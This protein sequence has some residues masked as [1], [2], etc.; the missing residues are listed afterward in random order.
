VS[1]DQINKKNDE[2]FTHFFQLHK[3]TQEQL[4]SLRQLCVHQQQ[5]IE[6]LEEKVAKLQM[7]QSEPDLRHLL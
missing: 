1:Q 3:L 7:Q 2:L 5:R 6:N 4:Q